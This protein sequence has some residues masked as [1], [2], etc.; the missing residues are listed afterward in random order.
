[1]FDQLKIL[2]AGISGKL[3]K[4]PT[5]RKYYWFFLGG[6]IMTLILLGYNAF[7]SKNTYTQLLE[8]WGGVDGESMGTLVTVVIAGFAFFLLSSITG[9]LLDAL[10]KRKHR[11]QGH[12]PLFFAACLTLVGILSLDIWA[13]FQGVGIVSHKTT[14]PIIDNPLSM[15]DT[16]YEADKERIESK[17][18]DKLNN[19]DLSI[20]LILNNPKASEPGHNAICKQ[21]CPYEVGTGAS[22]W[23][24]TVTKYGHKIV[25]KLRNQKEA[26]EDE[27]RG[28]LSDLTHAYK[29]NRAEESDNYQRDKTRYDSTVSIK[30][31]GHTMLVLLS[32]LIC[33]FISLGTNHYADRALSLINP[34]LEAEEIA[35]YETR[36]DR[37]EAMKKAVIA[38]YEIQG[39]QTEQ[40]LKQVL[41]YLQQVQ[42]GQSSKSNQIG[43]NQ[44][45]KP[46]SEGDKVQQTGVNP[47][48]FPSG[49][50]EQQKKI[51]AMIFGPPGQGVNPLERT[52]GNIGV[53]PP[54]NP[55]QM[56]SNVSLDDIEFLRKYE[57]VVRDTIE[58]A[59]KPEAAKNSEV[60]LSTVKNVRR[61]MKAVNLL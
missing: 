61:V 37:I 58:G 53:N 25:A 41:A 32:Y 46:S 34:D 55:G 24:G 21:T 57:Q 33:F 31:T 14:T 22:H 42:P 16:K 30:E 6:I 28:E 43:Y 23:N 10:A 60:S 7:M 39:N 47:L 56:G 19:I 38:K 26:L 3:K 52:G 48:G 4:A 12:G 8:R 11:L 51:Y 5:L 54:V 36:S 15:I 27:K 29:T 1:M 59:S 2:W 44:Q 20:N 45:D 50:T 9:T 13:N 49:L 17:Y 35:E 40:I 18:S